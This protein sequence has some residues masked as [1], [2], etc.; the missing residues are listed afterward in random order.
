MTG[1]ALLL[2]LASVWLAFGTLLV[3]GTVA[4]ARRQARAIWPQPRS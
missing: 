1:A 4:R 3:L 2:P